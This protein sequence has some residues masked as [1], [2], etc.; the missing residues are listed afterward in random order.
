MLFKPDTIPP[1]AGILATKIAHE[2]FFGEEVLAQCTVSG[3]RQ[4]PALPLKEL[5]QLKQTMFTQLPE[6]WGNPI[7]FES[8]WA[9]CSDAINQA[10][11]YA[12]VNL[13]KKSRHFCMLTPTHHS[14]TRVCKQL[15]VTSCR[16]I[17]TRSIAMWSTL[18][19]STCH[20][21]NSHEI[22]CHQINFYLVTQDQHRNNSQ[23]KLRY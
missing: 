3:F 10:C 2:A 15:G 1:K 22:K 21:I 18:M 11:K 6:F 16:S 19:W 20:E 12:R 8:V 9:L 13:Q 14:F 17:P 4:L 7:E 23:Q 5:N